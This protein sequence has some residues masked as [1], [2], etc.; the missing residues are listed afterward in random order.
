MGSEPGDVLQ[1]P[2]GLLCR[3]LEAKG[4]SY[5]AA[6]D[7]WQAAGQPSRMDVDGN[8]IPCETVYPVDDVAGYWEGQ[9]LNN[10]LGPGLLCQ[11][12]RARGVSY[13]D[14]VAYWYTE[15]RPDRMDVERNGIPCETVY[16]AAEVQQFWR[17]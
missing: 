14:A 8:G 11:D 10:G 5:A 2:A 7:Y 12:L 1:E 9:S 4:Y 15:G 16:P 13:A 6:I 17:R 3:D